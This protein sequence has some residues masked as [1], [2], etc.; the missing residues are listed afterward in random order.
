MSERTP[1]GRLDP[2][3]RSRNLRGALDRVHEVLEE[4]GIDHESNP[5]DQRVRMLMHQRD[6]LLKLLAE[7]ADEIESEGVTGWAEDVRQR[8]KQAQ[9][10]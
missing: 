7:V 4:A 5:A 3:E 10:G 9:E 8:T 1:F 6:A 2:S